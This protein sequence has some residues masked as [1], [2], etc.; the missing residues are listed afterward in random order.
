MDVG[1]PF[2]RPLITRFNETK[3]SQSNRT[4][5]SCCNG[6]EGKVPEKVKDLFRSQLV[7]TTGRLPNYQ[8]MSTKDL[9]DRVSCLVDWWIRG[10]W[11]GLAVLLLAML[12]YRFRRADMILYL[13]LPSAVMGNTVAN[14]LWKIY[15]CCYSYCIS[16]A[17]KT[18]TCDLKLRVGRFTTHLKNY[19]QIGS[20]PQV[21]MNMKYCLKPPPRLD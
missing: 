16:E 17:W 5:L 14:D 21:G 4:N 1:M 20:S 9:E 7:G 12:K 19:S 13:D 6:Q 11:L 3:T 15:L 10:D 2:H 18:W 8:S